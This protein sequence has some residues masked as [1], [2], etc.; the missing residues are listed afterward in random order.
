VIFGNRSRHAIM[1]LAL[2]GVSAASAALG[3][4]H[5]TYAY[6]AQGQLRAVGRSS[7]T[8]TYSYD[9][10]GNRTKLEIAQPQGLAVAAKGEALAAVDSGVVAN[11]F[12]IANGDQA[13]VRPGQTTTISALANDSDPDGD[14]LTITTVSASIGSA[15]IS[16]DGQQIAFTAPATAA[17]GTTIGLTY[18]ILDENGGTAFSTII[19]VVAAEGHG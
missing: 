8:V 5:T 10:A 3:Q 19:V 11:R 15:V 2:V 16:T 7:E 6:D 12:P 17:P 1:A 9:A 14:A 13:L 4:V 18:T